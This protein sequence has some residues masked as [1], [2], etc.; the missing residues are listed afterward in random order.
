MLF[1]ARFHICKVSECH[2][3]WRLIEKP[4]FGGR[5]DG[6]IF[7]CDSVGIRL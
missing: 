5:R 1:P 2:I 3:L 4:A 7:A 6:R